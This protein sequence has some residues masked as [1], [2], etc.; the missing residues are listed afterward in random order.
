MGLLTAAM[1]T[2]FLLALFPL[3]L[4]S[5]PYRRNTD[6]SN[7]PLNE[8]LQETSLEP[9]NTQ[10]GDESLQNSPDRSRNSREAD[11]SPSTLKNSKKQPTKF[12]KDSS[13]PSRIKKAGRRKGYPKSSYSPPIPS[14][15][16]PPANEVDLEQQHTIDAPKTDRRVSEPSA[17]TSTFTSN[18]SS[19]SPSALSTHPHKPADAKGGGRGDGLF[20]S[21]GALYLALYVIFALILFVILYLFIKFAMYAQSTVISRT[22]NSY[23]RKLENAFS[24]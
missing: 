10:V 1:T 14:D 4:N 11:G 2:A 23:I 20:A 19:P 13:N 21:E 22:C 18:T 24:N 9:E 12:S 5:I 16:A 6:G 8:Y 3:S 15:E 17:S 7:D